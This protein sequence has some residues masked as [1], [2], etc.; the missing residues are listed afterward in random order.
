MSNSAFKREE[1]KHHNEMYIAKRWREQNGLPEW[2]NVPKHVFRDKS[3]DG[4][5]PELYET[6][7]SIHPDTKDALRAIDSISITPA[8]QSDAIKEVQ[9]VGRTQR[10]KRE[11]EIVVIGAGQTAVGRSVMRSAGLALAQKIAFATPEILGEMSREETR[12]QIRAER[13]RYGKGF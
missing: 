7:D 8:P 13:G 10:P 9:Q 3:L 12:A 1:A 2:A 6:I 4:A 11:N 5:C